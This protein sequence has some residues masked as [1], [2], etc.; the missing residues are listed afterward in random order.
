M[1]YCNLCGEIEMD[2]NMSGIFDDDGNNINP[3]LIPKPSLCVSCKKDG[4]PGEEGILCVLTRADQQD[5]EE[6]Q[7]YAY[8]PKGMN[9]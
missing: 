3:D 4:I 9:A 6:F 1:A 2:E 5:E 7:C 8:E